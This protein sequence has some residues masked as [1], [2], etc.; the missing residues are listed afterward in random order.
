MVWNLQSYPTTVLNEWTFWGI[1]TYSDPSYIFRVIRT[2]TQPGSTS[3]HVSEVPPAKRTLRILKCATAT[4]AWHHDFAGVNLEMR[5][6]KYN[7]H[8]VLTANKLT[9]PPPKFWETLERI[10]IVFFLSFLFNTFIIIL[11]F[12]CIFFYCDMDPCGLMQINWL[13]DICFKFGT[14][15]DDGSLLRPDHKMTPKWAWPGSRDQISKFWDPLITLER[16]EISAS[17]LA[18]A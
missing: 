15:I 1:K 10:E 12:H 6:R 3:C 5:K 8:D 7:L 18:Q 9:Y 17:N 16:I 11:S 14:N 4:V 13:I 2:P